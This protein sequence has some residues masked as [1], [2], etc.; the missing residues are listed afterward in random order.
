MSGFITEARNRYLEVMVSRG[1]L[2]KAYNQSD[3]AELPPSIDSLI[4]PRHPVRMV[5]EIIDEIDLAPI[6]A[7]YPGG[8]SPSYHPRMMLKVWVYGY[9]RNIYS[10]RKLELAISEHIHFMWLS[11]GNCP[12]HNSL[13][14]FRSGR[15]EGVLQE[16]FSQV[17]LAL[18][19]I[20]YLNIKDIYTDGTKIAANSY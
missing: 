4:G 15:L 8:G 1:K 14:R 3:F 10:S 19:A 5:S 2:F 17:V 20:G 7:K 11:G 18:H 12:D 13:S 9:I 16:V 6:V